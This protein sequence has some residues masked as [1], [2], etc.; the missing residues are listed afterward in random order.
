M[1]GTVHVYRREKS[2]FWQCAVYLSG[3]NHRSTTGQTSLALAMD[4]ARE[5]YID[6]HAEDGSGGAACPLAGRGG[7]ARGLAEA[8]AAVE[9][10]GAIVRGGRR[11]VHAEFRVITQGERNDAYVDGKEASLAVS[12]T[13]PW[14]SGGQ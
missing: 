5:W 11:G 14:R 3:R 7:G 9:A 2:G 6:R 8:H 4:F 1:D 10:E 12:D 13:V